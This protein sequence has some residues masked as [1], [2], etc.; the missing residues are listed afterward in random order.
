MAVDSRIGSIVAGFRVRSAI[1]RGATGD[2]YLAEDASGGRVALKLLGAE[3]AQ[4]ERFRR[5]FL[6]ESELAAG[7][8]HPNVVRTLAAGDEAGV[9]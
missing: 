6:R 8:D 5:R 2:V 1:G 4:D 7:L 3:V 9:L